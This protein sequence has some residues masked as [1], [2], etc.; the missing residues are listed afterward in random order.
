MD[1]MSFFQSQHTLIPFL[2]VLAIVFGIL[3][4]VKVFGRNR[5]VNFLISVSIAFFS[6]TD[7]AFVN[8][9]W[10]YFGSITTFFIV[11]FFI[12]FVLEIFGIRRGSPKDDSTIFIGGAILLILL[13]VG[14][15]I[16]SQL[17]EL[18]FI[19][20][21]SNLIA[22]VGLIF[23]LSIFWAAFKIGSGPQPQA[24]KQAIPLYGGLNI[25]L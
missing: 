21:G 23:I 13:S 6:V 18:P 22:L 7:E 17:P 10:T 15:M 5:G 11:L 2:F 16:S 24:P 19:G 25:L 9:L 12:A 3:E 8:L 4:N 14:Y 1:F 20:G